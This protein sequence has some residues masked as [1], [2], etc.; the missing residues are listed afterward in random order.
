[1]TALYV[2]VIHYVLFFV[3]F[4]SGLNQPWK[5]AVRLSLLPP[6]FL[7]LTCLSVDQAMPVLVRGIWTFVPL[8]SL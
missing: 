4:P 2:I 8:G 6:G 1:M 3:R 5:T 7:N